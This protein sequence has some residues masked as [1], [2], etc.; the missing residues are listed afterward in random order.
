M[1]PK[2]GMKLKVIQ[3]TQ[4]DL[5]PGQVV[6]VTRVDP[7]GDFWTNGSDMYPNGICFNDFS[8]RDFEVVGDA[9]GKITTGEAEARETQQILDLLHNRTTYNAVNDVYGDTVEVFNNMAALSSLVE[10]LVANGTL[11]LAQVERTLK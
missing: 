11:T 4:Y 10:V 7:Y 5:I 6:D 3:D 8:M 2:V 9:P 1:L